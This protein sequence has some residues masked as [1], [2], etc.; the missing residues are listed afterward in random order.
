MR[1]QVLT[2]AQSAEWMRVLGQCPC[3]D[4]YHLPQYHALAEDSGE[5]EALLF[6]HAEGVYSIALPLLIRSLDGLPGIQPNGTRWQDATSVYG[7]A[8][9]IASHSNIPESVVQNFQASLQRRLSGLGVVTVFSRLHPIIGQQAFLDGMGECRTLGRTVSIDLTLP[10]AAQ[11]AAFRKSV[12]G[13][14]NKLR[15]QSVEVVHDREGLYLDIFVEMYYETMR[16]VGAAPGYFF[17][18]DYFR[19]LFTALGERFHLFVCLRKGEVMCG[20]IFIECGGILQYHLGGTMNTAL[21]FAPTKMLFD[22]IRIWANARDL[23]FFHLGGGATLSP[24]DSLLHFKLGFSGR[25]HD[26]AV[27]RWVLLPDVY[28]RLCTER[29][30]WNEENGIASTSTFFPEYR[31]P[32]IPHVLPPPYLVSAKTAPLPAGVHP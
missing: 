28:G 16:R 13:G 23:K 2:T 1:M 6:H 30:R 18:L 20:G 26:F 27:W 4:F 9:P 12:K 22:D 15:R 8:G 21:E 3:H 17:T 24:D 11:Y 25:T 14:I 32:A 29:S 31:A 5:G 7:Y 10:A 19:K